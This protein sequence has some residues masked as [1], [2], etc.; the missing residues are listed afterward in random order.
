[1]ILWNVDS[2]RALEFAA[3]LEITGPIEVLPFLKPTG[4]SSFDEPSS[5]P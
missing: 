3:N 1:M 5:G 2:I 4:K